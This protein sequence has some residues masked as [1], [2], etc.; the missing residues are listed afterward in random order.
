VI[1]PEKGRAK[2][3]RYREAHPEKIREYRKFRRPLYRVSAEKL[4]A[5]NAINKAIMSGKITKPEV[6]EACGDRGLTHGHHDDYSKKLE[7]RWLCAPC[8]GE[9]HRLDTK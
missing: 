8:H 6:C 2:S 7:V 3:K 5:R 4:S 9:V 1:D